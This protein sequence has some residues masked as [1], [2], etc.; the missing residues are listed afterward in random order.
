MLRRSEA[1]FDAEVRAPLV[2]S[3]LARGRALAQAEP[4]VGELAAIVRKGDVT[5]DIPDSMI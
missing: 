4:A 5:L 3:V 1:V 2:E